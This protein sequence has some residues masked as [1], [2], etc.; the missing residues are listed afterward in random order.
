MAGTTWGLAAIRESTTTLLLLLS[1]VCDN[2]TPSA[3]SVE[4][5]LESAEPESGTNLHRLSRQ[6]DEAPP[7]RVIVV[8]ATNR[9]ND[10]DV[11]IQ[12]RFHRKVHVGL[13]SE[14]ERSKM[15]V[16]FLD[17]IEHDCSTDDVLE[18]AQNTEGWSGAD[19]RNVIREA[20]LQPLRRMLAEMS[21]PP[22]EFERGN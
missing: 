7:P 13:P 5:H 2:A 1:S 8:A 14:A 17:G 15:I 3:S 22:E 16:S 11:A 10:I 21:K 19:L 18:F 6:N 9:L 12:R 4:P 20:A